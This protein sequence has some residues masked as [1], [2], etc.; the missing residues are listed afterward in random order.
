MSKIE[1]QYVYEKIW[2]ETNE[3]DLLKIIGEEVGDADPKGVLS[4][5]Q[6]A[7]KKSKM[8]SVGDCRFRH[9]I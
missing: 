2:H 4:Y 7:L 5:I 8:I 9:K 3:E 6:E 1:T